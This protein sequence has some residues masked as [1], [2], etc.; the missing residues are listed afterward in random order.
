MF[1]VCSVDFKRVLQLP[2]MKH[3]CHPETALGQILKI[4]SSY[5]KKLVRS[6]TSCSILTKLFEKGLDKHDI[7]T[8][9]H[10]GGG[11]SSPRARTTR[12]VVSGQWSVVSGQWFQPSRARGQP[13]TPPLPPRPP[14]LSS[15]CARTTRQVASAAMRGVTILPAHEDNYRPGG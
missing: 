5:L 1:S 8:G 7:R 3:S 11:P 6:V 12:L 10:Q 14:P 2:P 9:T 15:P 13:A 4:I